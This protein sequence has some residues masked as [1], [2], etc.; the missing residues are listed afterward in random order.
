[1]FGDFVVMDLLHGVCGLYDRY[2]FV[3]VCFCV[4]FVFFFDIFLRMGLRKLKWK[5]NKRKRT[6][7]LSPFYIDLPLFLL[8]FLILI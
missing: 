5:R 4:F 6:T 2:V 3:C 8:V 7:N 1:M